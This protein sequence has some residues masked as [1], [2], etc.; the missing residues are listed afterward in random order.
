MIY[1]HQRSWLQPVQHEKTQ[2]HRHL[3]AARNSKGQRRNQ[4]TSVFRIDRGLRRDHARNVA[5]AERFRILGRAYC[6]A[7]GQER[8]HRSTHAGNRPH[9]RPDE[10]TAQYRRPVPER[11]HQAARHA[12]N[13]H[14]LRIFC[15]RPARHRELEHFRQGEKSDQRRHQMNAVP[16]VL[17]SAGE[18]QHARDIVV[19]DKRNQKAETSRH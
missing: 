1:Q 7:V 8:R 16:Q 9:D 2:E 5:L 15:D 6:H 11:F 12:G 17:D 14:R 4:A 10:R 3:E 19:A 18:A 13:L